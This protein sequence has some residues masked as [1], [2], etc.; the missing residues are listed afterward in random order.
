LEDSGAKGNTRDRKVYT[1]TEHGRRI[2][3]D[4]IA[5][6]QKLLKVAH[7]YVIEEHA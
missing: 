5:H 4:E 2:L 7:R 6:L 3:K 1:L